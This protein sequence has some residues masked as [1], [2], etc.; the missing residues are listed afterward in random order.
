MLKDTTAVTQVTSDLVKL[1]NNRELTAK[2]IRKSVTPVIKTCTEA[3]TFL[4]HA[5]QEAGPIG[6]TNIA[7]SLPKDSYPLVKDVPI[8]SEW[9]FCDDINARIKNIKAQQKAFKVN[10]NYFKSERI[11]DRQAYFPKQNSKTSDGFPKISANQNKG[12]KDKG[13]K[14]TYKKARN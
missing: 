10:K 6:R 1:K 5:N 4:G 13:A 12:Y 2:D 3:M 9:V 8:P 11:F 14:Q 7:M